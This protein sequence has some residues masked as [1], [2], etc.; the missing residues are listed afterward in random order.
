VAIRLEPLR[1]DESV[2]SVELKLTVP[3]GEERATA[4]ALGIDLLDAQL[5]QVYFFDTPD[6]TLFEQ[7]VVLRARRI[8]NDDHDC[9][10]KLRPVLPSQL[11]PRWRKAEGMGVEVDVVGGKPI[12]S[13]SL[14]AVR[15]PTR[16]EEVLDGEVPLPRLFRKEQRAFL[17]E[18]APTAIPWD[19]LVPL[20]PINVAKVKM[21]VK[22]LSYPVVA[23]AWFYPDGS[24]LLELSMKMKPKRV[25]RARQ[26]A[27][28]YLESLGLKLGGGEQQTKTRK[29]LLFFSRKLTAAS[30]H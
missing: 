16:I 18:H 22:G 6:L 29:A 10:V 12:Y 20:G 30:A 14:K 3:Q 1:L 28:A 5:R 23:E 13:A 24:A 2:D 17:D 21:P 11:A 7:G 8:Q 15:R 9:V 25:E 4:R 26:E 27:K 19:R